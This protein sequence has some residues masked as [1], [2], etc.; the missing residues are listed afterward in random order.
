MA[1]EGDQVN[2]PEAGAT[3]FIVGCNIVVDKELV[4]PRLVW[5][6]LCRVR[7]CGHHTDTHC[8]AVDAALGGA[9]LRACAWCLAGPTTAAAALRLVDEEPRG[10]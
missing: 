8:M 5:R 1:R 9:R 6:A 7:G 10:L 2:L 4:W 3:T